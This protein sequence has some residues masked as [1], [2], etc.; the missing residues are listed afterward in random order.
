LL[1]GI[2]NT[3]AIVNHRHL[4]VLVANPLG[5]PVR[6]HRRAVVEHLRLLAG[7]YPDDAGLT[8]LIGELCIKSPEFRAAWA[9]QRLHE[10]LHGIKRIHN[11]VLGDLELQYERLVISG[12]PEHA[13]RTYAAEPSS[14]TPER[15]AM[16][17]S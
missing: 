3:P 13:L 4:V 8:P 16:L 11:P 2:P 17:A 6:P 9:K 14:P 1:D 5:S 10:K 12:E 7:R 15:L